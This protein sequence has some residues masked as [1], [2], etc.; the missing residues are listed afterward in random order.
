MAKCFQCG[1]WFWVVFALRFSDEGSVAAGK[2]I[3]ECRKANPE[4]NSEVDGPVC[5]G[6]FQIQAAK[7]VVAWVWISLIMGK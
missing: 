4:L 1:L 6:P 7:V 2:M 3:R 5:N